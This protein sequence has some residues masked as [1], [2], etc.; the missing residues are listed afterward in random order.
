MWLGRQVIWRFLLKKIE[1]ALLLSSI[2]KLFSN[3]VTNV[4]PVNCPRTVWP[5][6]R[7][8][9]RE[10]PCTR[11]QY[12]YILYR[13]EFQ[14][15][16]YGAV[17][18]YML[19]TSAGTMTRILVRSVV[20]LNMF[21]IIVREAIKHLFF[22]RLYVLPFRWHLACIGL[23]HQLCIAIGY[24]KCIHIGLRQMYTTNVLCW[25]YGYKLTVCFFF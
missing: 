21:F 16:V 4:V 20:G 9:Y 23:M 17:K 11:Q 7:C 8:L 13:M 24:N 14:T 22:F 18:A 3:F 12:Q 5:T 2:K 19:Y 6:S 25:L 10:C 15:A 1:R